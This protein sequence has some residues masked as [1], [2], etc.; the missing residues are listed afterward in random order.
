MYICMYVCVYVCTLATAYTVWANKLTFEPGSLHMINSKRIF[1]FFEKIIYFWVIP[2]LSFFTIFF[3]SRLWTY[4]L[5]KSICQ[6]KATNHWKTLCIVW[7][8]WINSDVIS[9]FG[10]MCDINTF[11]VQNECAYDTLLMYIHSYCN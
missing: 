1:Y 11:I 4:L 3:I 5:R 7:L 6:I 2:R 10:L 8:C 9:K